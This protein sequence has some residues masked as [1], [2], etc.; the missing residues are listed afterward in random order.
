MPIFPSKNTKAEEH[1][2]YLNA[3]QK[4]LENFHTSSKEEQSLRFP[5]IKQIESEVNEQLKIFQSHIKDIK[6]SSLRLEELIKMFKSGEISENAYKLLMD[7][8]SS[9]LSLSIEGIF[10]VRESLE[11]LRARAK[12]EWA[13]EKLDFEVEKREMSGKTLGEEQYYRREVYSPLYKWQEIVNRI[14]EALSSLKFEDELSIIE[15][16][17]LITRERKNVKTKEVEEALEICRQ[18]LN[19]LSEK[20]AAVRRDKISQVMNL[21]LKASQIRDEIKEVE[22][23]FA[24]G[25][26]SRSIY[27][28]RMSVLQGSLRKVEKEISEI[29][30]YIDEI[31][32]KIFR[33]SE[34]L[35]EMV[36]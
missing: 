31:D 27:E 20:W 24:V 1:K 30:G 25:E 6:Y 15:R 21:E 12:I 16:Y 8:L 33:I 18:R 28:S 34:L 9:S 36:E 5:T 3:A 7:E 4:R 17:L 10:R 32:L 2:R 22:V 13:K 26:L 19:I 14:D 23:R 35:R 29:R 11:I